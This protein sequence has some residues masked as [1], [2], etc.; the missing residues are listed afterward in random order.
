MIDCVS[1]T[2]AVAAGTPAGLNPV[3]DSAA[4]SAASS[5]AP[6][7]M[8]VS[9]YSGTTSRSPAGNTTRC[10]TRR[11]RPAPFSSVTVAPQAC[12]RLTVGEEGTQAVLIHAQ[13]GSDRHVHV[14]VLVRAQPTAEE[15]AGLAPRHVPVSQQPFPVR[16][17]VD[18]IVRLVAAVGEARELPHDHC[19]V[20]R[21]PVTF[22]VEVPEF[23]DPGERNV[24]VCVVH[25]RRALEIAG[26]EDLHVEVE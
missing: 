2:A 12:Q 6:R 20:L 21:V 17:G 25:D 23:V 14:E 26:G 5:A 16:R 15:H 24:R 4:T 8:L 13:R 3:I 11:A 9:T 19:L 7:S 18:G 22:G 1:P 10:T